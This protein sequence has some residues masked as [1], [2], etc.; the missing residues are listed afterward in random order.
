MDHHPNFMV[1]KPQVNHQHDFGIKGRG[2]RFPPSFEPKK[3]PSDEETTQIALDM[4]PMGR[5]CSVGSLKYPDEK[6]ACVIA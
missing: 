1:A 6:G 2:F 5:G 4:L 3:G